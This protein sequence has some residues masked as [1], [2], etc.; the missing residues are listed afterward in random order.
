[1]RERIFFLLGGAEVATL[2]LR[3][4]QNIHSLLDV[5]LLPGLLELLNEIASSLDFPL[6]ISF[7]LL[8][9]RLLVSFLSLLLLLLSFVLDHLAEISE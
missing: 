4:H 9:L 1:M 2:L 3:N 8:V 6:Q 7:L 5:L